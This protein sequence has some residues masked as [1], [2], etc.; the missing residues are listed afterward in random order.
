MKIITLFICLTTANLIAQEQ[1]PQQ[2][3]VS[4]HLD[5]VQPFRAAE[6]GFEISRNDLLSGVRA[7]SNL[8][9]QNGTDFGMTDGLGGDEPK[10]A[11]L[12]FARANQKDD[13][14]VVEFSNLRIL[15]LD[16]IRVFSCNR[17]ARS[18]QNYDLALSS[19]GGSTWQP[20]ATGVTAKK[21]GALAVTRVVAPFDAVTNLRFTFRQMRNNTHSAILEIDALGEKQPDPTVKSGDTSTFSIAAVADV[22][23]ADT[24]PRR[25]RQPGEGVARLTHAVNQWNQRDL[26]WAVMLGDIIDWDD[27]DYGKFPHKTISNGAP[28]WKHTRAVLTVWEKLQCKRFLVLGNHDYYV[29]FADTDGLQKPASVRRAYGMGDTAYYHFLHKGYR[30]IVLDGDLSPY[31]YAPDTLGYKEA[32][33]YYDSITG[34]HKRWWNAGI[35]P[36]QLQWLKGILDQS[37]KDRERVV[38]MCH[39]PTHKPFGDHDLLNAEE[40]LSLLDQYPNIA[41]WLNGHNHR[42]NYTKIGARHHLTLK[43]MQNGGKHWY[44]I[45]F[46]PTGIK[47]YQ[48]ENTKD[49]LYTLSLPLLD[50]AKSNAGEESR[51]VTNSFLRGCDI[52][53]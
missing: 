28:K 51:L 21:S 22:Q 42:G 38:I 17:D 45:T 49:P 15:R 16:E 32:K 53:D 48:A 5:E 26:D 6:A 10:G 50:A 41:L 44:Q 1:E 9:L 13:P 43:G 37:L 31:N 52:Q 12:V 3:A 4:V 34:S 24:D 20:V 46:S 14:W 11:H 25:G 7:Q 40:V 8:K 39:Y 29:P 18:R 23:Y 2:A 35:S 36:Q 30:F 33:T 47:V 19:D 27:I